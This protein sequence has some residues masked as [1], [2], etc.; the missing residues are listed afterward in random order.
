MQL[1]DL[2]SAMSAGFGHFVID[3]FA[4]CVASTVVCCFMIVTLASSFEMNHV[5]L[6]QSLTVAAL[7][8]LSISRILTFVMSGQRLEDAV[9]RAIRSL[10]DAADENFERI[11]ERQRFRLQVLR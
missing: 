1:I 9:R 2:V 7:V 6:C 3:S 8:T 5:R 10:E 11:S 4:F